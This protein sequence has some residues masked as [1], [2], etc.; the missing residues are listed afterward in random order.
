[1]NYYSIKYEGSI[2]QKTLVTNLKPKACL[3]TFQSFQNFYNPIDNVTMDGKIEMQMVN[4]SIH[5]E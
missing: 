4:M 1:M 5:T 2:W 3:K